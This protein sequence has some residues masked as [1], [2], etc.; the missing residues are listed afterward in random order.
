MTR[1]HPLIAQEGWPFVATLILALLVALGLGLA[2][3]LIAVLASALVAALLVFRD[4][5]RTVPSLPNSVVAPVDGRLLEVLRVSDGVLPGDWW[6]LRIRPNPLGA[7][8]VRSPIEGQIL[9][10]RVEGRHSDGRRGP[11]GLW[12]SSE[13]RDETVLVFSGPFWMPRPQ[14]FVSYGE[15][16]GQGQ[17][18]AYLRLAF[19]AELYLPATA[20]LRV[21]AGEGLRAGEQ[22]IAD[23]YRA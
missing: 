2:T 19:Q 18:F 4:P 3:W 11:A 20:E 10:P 6:C 14:A 13:E 17:R 23:L 12:L 9:D 21:A 22:A 8:T 16:L 15:R 7:Y 1:N 5:V